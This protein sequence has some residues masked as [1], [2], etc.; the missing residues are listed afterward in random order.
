MSAHTSHVTAAEDRLSVGQKFSYGL[1]AIANNMLGGAIG[2]MSIVLN[3]GLGMNP[4]LVGTLQAIPRLTDALTDPVMGY[5]S[6]NTRSRYGR[7]RPYIFIGGILVGLIFALMWQLP[8]GYSEMFYFWFFLAGS[9]LFYLAYTIFATP[10][11]ALG[12]EMTPDYHE[13]TRLMASQNFMG[14]F[15]WISLPWFY[16]IMENDRFFSDSVEG[17]RVL[18]IIIG[19]F[20]AVLAVS[21]A[22]FCRERFVAHE[23]EDDNKPSGIGHNI[24]EFFKGFLITIKNKEFLKLCLGTF[25]LFNGIMLVGSFGSYITIFYVVG[26]DTD[27]GATYMGLYGT[28]TTVSTLAAIVAVTWVSSRIGKRRAFIIAT[29]ITLFGCLIKWWCYDPL[30]PWKVLIPAPFISVGMGGLFTLMGSMIADVV[31]GDELETGFRREGMFGSIY[32]WVVKLGMA[33]AFGLSGFLLNG[34]GFDVEMMGAQTS[35]TFLYMRLFDVFIPVVASTIAIIA[36][37]S[38]KITE[39]KSYEI[40]KALEQRRG[41]PAQTDEGLLA[42]GV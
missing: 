27:L 31:D 9:I 8:A 2:Y 28:V 1:G 7:R 3:V 13:R 40:R 36:V 16:A 33:L 30:V 21:S 41:K 37:A 4:A 32:W 19:V 38:F 15:A 42:D 5:I 25:F 17:A 34:T 12:Y 11:V 24:K 35:D 29:S 39:E 10:W 22:I 18:A 26:G 6:D 14:Q 23:D 20:V